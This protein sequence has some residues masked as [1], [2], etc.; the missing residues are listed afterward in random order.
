[1]R[2]DSSAR[3]LIQRLVHLGHDVKTIQNMQGL[4]AFLTNDLQIGFPH[5]RADEDDLRGDLFTYGGEESLERLNGSFLAHPEQADHAQVDLIHQRQVLVALGVLDFIYA[6]GVDLDQRAVLQPKGD[7]VFDGIENLIPGSAEHRGRFLPGEPTGPAGQKQHVGF[8]QGVF[9]VAPGN[10]LDHHGAAT[11]AIHAAHGVQEKHQESPQGNELK[12]PLRELIVTG[13]R[14]M[15]AG[16]D[17]RRTTA[18]ADDDFDV[19]FIGT[20]AGVLVD[21]PSE[22]VAA[23]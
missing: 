5:I 22:M 1:M 7:H 9:A 6:D 13:R 23:V 16:A 20:E 19:L 10:F 15:T 11:V 3:N 18:G 14:L 8:G 12:T 21:E 2:R 17:G 4:G